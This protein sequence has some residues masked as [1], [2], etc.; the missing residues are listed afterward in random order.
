MAILC[1][2]V[3]VSALFLSSGIGIINFK[4]WSRK[5]LFCLLSLRIIYALA[6]CLIC[7]LIHLH[8][9]II[10]AVSLFLFYYL[11]RPKVTR[12]FSG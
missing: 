10:L 7:S 1:I 5:L 8:L 4:E 6:I 11:T 9:G 3:A 12:V 2:K